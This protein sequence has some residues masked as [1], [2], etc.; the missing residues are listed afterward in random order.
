MIGRGLGPLL[1]YYSDDPLHMN[2]DGYRVLGRSLAEYLSTVERDTGDL[3]V[4]RSTVEPA[5]L[6]RRV[7]R[8]RWW[9]STLRQYQARAE[10]LN[11]SMLKACPGESG[12]LD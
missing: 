11:R 10:N 12:K 5:W 7:M 2:R 1:A 9:S 6:Q 8:T 3:R 4:R